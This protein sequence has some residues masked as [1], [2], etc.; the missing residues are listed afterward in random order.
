MRAGGYVGA[1]RVAA[2][3]ICFIVDYLRTA[4]GAGQGAVSIRD[5]RGLTDW[6]LD[7]RIQVRTDR[8]KPKTT[9]M[10]ERALRVDLHLHSDAS[11]LKQLRFMRMRDCYSPPIEVYRRAKARGMDLVTL[12]DHDSIDGC[13]ELRDLLGD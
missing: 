11:R 4:T 10:N 13:L 5:L 9:T 1:R 8:E 6:R 2:A 7:L 3:R 12:T